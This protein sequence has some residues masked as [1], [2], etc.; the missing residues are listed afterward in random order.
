MLY[1]RK[2]IRVQVTPD[3]DV[4]YDPPLRALEIFAGDGV[5]VVE[6]AFTNTLI[7]K[8]IPAAADGGGYP[9]I[10]EVNVRRVMATN[11]TLVADIV[12]FKG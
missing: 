7:T 6:E 10:W 12:G 3:D 5:L 9:Y 2:T 1:S 8:T 4:V 11:T